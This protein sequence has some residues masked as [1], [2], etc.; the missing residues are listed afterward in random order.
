MVSPMIKRKQIRRDNREL[1]AVRKRDAEA[2][3]QIAQNKV[4]HTERQ[5]QRQTRNPEFMK[6][7]Q[8]SKDKSDSKT[9]QISRNKF[10]PH[11]HQR[12][13]K[14][15]RGTARIISIGALCFCVYS[16]ISAKSI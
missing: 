7:H 4:Q 2:E 13:D 11:N 14:L 3:N 8:F 15:I 1:A 5:I 10:L 12:T 6:I 9:E 16:S